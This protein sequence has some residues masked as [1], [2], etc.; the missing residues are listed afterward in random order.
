M[1]PV[2]KLVYNIFTSF[3]N[4]K[5]KVNEQIGEGTYEADK[6]QNSNLTVI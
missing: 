4:H 6:V 5:A 3:L 1:G 2:I